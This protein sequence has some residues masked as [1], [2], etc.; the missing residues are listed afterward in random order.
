[1]QFIDSLFL[2]L[3]SLVV[4]SSLILGIGALLLRWLPQPSERVR[5]VQ[6]TFFALVAVLL[7]RLVG[8]FD[9]ITLEII[10]AEWTT[11]SRQTE[12]LP[13]H[14]TSPRHSAQA[15]APLDVVFEET[16]ASEID[17]AE[18]SANWGANSSDVSVDAS[19]SHGSVVDAW[20]LLRAGCLMLFAGGLL[21]SLLAFWAGCRQLRAL[22]QSATP[23]DSAFLAHWKY[24]NLASIRGV[25]I[26]ASPHIKSPLTFGVFSS[27]IVMPEGLLQSSQNETS[28]C[29]L[30]HELAHILNGDII[31]HWAVRLFQPLLW[32]QPL[33]WHFSRELTVAQDQLADQFVL[34]ETADSSTYAELLLQFSQRQ[35]S[36][37]L[38]FGGRPSMIRRRIEMLLQAN[39]VISPRARWRP[40]VT[41]AMC[42][43]VAS[44]IVGIVRISTFQD[45][46]RL[47]AQINI[48]EAVDS[49][50]PPEN[51]GTAPT[52]DADKVASTPDEHLTKL[53]ADL[54]LSVDDDTGTAVGAIKELVDMGPEAVPALID[55]LP[56]A[57][58]NAFRRIPFVLRA[59]GDERAVPALIESIP[60]CLEFQNSS[61]MGLREEGKL[62]TFLR[63]NDL[64]EKND[65]P[66]V[67]YNLG[68][69]LREVM[70][71]LKKM[72]GQSFGATRI[73]FV[74]A[75]GSERQ[76]YLAQKQFHLAAVEWQT[77][78]NDRK[79]I[80]LGAYRP[81]TLPPLPDSPPR[82]VFDKSARFQESEGAKGI[83]LGTVQSEPHYC[84]YDIDTGATFEWPD[85]PP[86]GPITAAL[87]KVLLRKNQQQLMEWGVDLVCFDI[88]TDNGEP[89]HELFSIGLNFRHLANENEADLVLGEFA[90]R[91]NFGFPPRIE[92]IQFL[93]TLN[94]DH[95]A[96]T[97][98]FFHTMDD[99][100]GVMTVNTRM[101]K[102]EA[103][104]AFYTGM[105]F[106][107]R[108]YMPAEQDTLTPIRPA[109][110]RP[111]LPPNAKG[112][113]K[114]L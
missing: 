80:K 1:M 35:T 89:R 86:N 63:M 101:Q 54:N 45:S 68:R 14:G 75:R 73:N 111:P 62:S 67:E 42:L 46:R 22:L 64:D 30:N 51:T 33:Y 87:A 59:I 43:V 8:A 107:K 100:I 77:W 66:G 41:M 110:P 16:V 15:S 2:T 25:R 26:L 84:C 3:V 50:N 78:W 31:T 38:T 7:L 47:Q 60:R 70:G 34:N 98:V 69:P 76:K 19:P 27:V 106:D 85:A 28:D 95:P 44:L 23:V 72:T 65:F 104:G 92:A 36:L 99:T 4:I 113:T 13:P 48:A 103:P 57:E 21:W 109:P 96:P 18:G 6:L 5:C 88:T 12:Q 32:W 102:G 91:G 55:A 105:K 93:P 39:Q 71:A 97:H 114:N 40:V 108:I 112:S 9:V 74:H 58:M 56:T 81:V 17:N 94:D 61:D 90:L 11:V 79:V 37:A 83:S 10:P 29:C 53:I 82:V 49:P 24:L 52:E 20:L